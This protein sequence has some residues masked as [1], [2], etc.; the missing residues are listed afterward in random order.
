MKNFIDIHSHILPG[1][2]D[3]AKNYE[4]SLRML[5]CAAD[6]G[7][8]VMILTPHHNKPGHRK[9]QFSE[10]ISGAEKLRSM[11][12]EENVKI[13]LYLGSEL[14]YQSGISE[15]MGNDMAGTLAGSRYLLVEFNPLA[16]YGYIR[17]GIYSLL[18]KG[19]YP[20]LAHAERYQSV[21]GRKDGIEDLIE[22]GCYIQVN[23]GSVTG[24][25]GLKTRRFVK[26]MLQQGQVHFV[27]TDAHDLEKRPPH[28]SECAELIRKKFGED[29]SRKLFYD[30][31][32]HVIK[33]KRL[34]L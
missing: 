29:Y 1:V 31:P 14:H 16:D 18:M 28:L 22:M 13:E 10:M 21:C 12:S 25:S 27:A 8:S 9:I 20:V 3:G 30:N 33:D 26:K 34:L 6:D 17:N 2:D 19:Y 4:M 24:K 23:A 32:M 15:K 7:I 5:K 11:M